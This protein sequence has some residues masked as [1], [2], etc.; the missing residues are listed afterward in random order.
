[1]QSVEGAQSSTAGADSESEY[2]YLV[3][4]GNRVLSHLAAIRG[5]QVQPPSR[6]ELLGKY[7]ALFVADGLK[8][9]SG[10]RQRL[11]YIFHRA[12]P[13]RKALDSAEL[14]KVYIPEL[15]WSEVHRGSVL[16]VRTLTAARDMKRVAGGDDAVV[17]IVEDEFGSVL[18]LRVYNL[19]LA[20]NQPRNLGD[21]LPPGVVVAIKEPYCEASSEDLSGIRVDH[22]S[23]L[24]YLT[25]G[26]SLFPA[27]WK[28]RFEDQSA[29][30]S[31]ALKDQG[32]ALYKDKKY[33]LSILKYV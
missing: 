20:G 13:C 32:N 2:R 10:E 33:R 26:N 21:I 19:S 11:T 22:P 15:R 3:D 7:D 16:V 12:P 18:R 23:D 28:H 30:P 31:E 25:E 17:T 1:M 8:S 14:K 4:Y 6:A 27:E 24:C 29:S 9:S 5:R